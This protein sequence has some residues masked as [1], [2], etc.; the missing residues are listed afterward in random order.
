MMGHLSSWAVA[1]LSLEEAAHALG[2]SRRKMTSIIAEHP[3]YERRGRK[4][5]FYPEHIEGI[6][7]ALRCVNGHPIGNQSGRK[8]QVGKSISRSTAT[9]FAEDLAF[10]TRASG[11]SRGKPQ[12]SSIGT[13][14]TVI[15]IRHR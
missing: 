12:R 5:V 1:P 11:T 15:S 2:V 6:R 9:E 8:R 13:P 14:G 4:K 3:L 10:V 7:K